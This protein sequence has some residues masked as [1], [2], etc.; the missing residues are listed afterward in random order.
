MFVRVFFASCAFACCV[1]CITQ[2][3]LVC[4]LRTCILFLCASVRLC[5]RLCLV[6]VCLWFVSSC[7]IP[8]FLVTL[9]ELIPVPG[10]CVFEVHIS[11]SVGI[12]C[13]PACLS[14]CNGP[15]VIVAVFSLL[16]YH[17]QL[18]MIS[19]ELSGLTSL[20]LDS[21]DVGDVGVRALSSMTRLEVRLLFA[22]K[23][24]L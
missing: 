15:L 1:A 20:I 6:F 14:V 24:E 2:W 16:V 17:Q 4:F 7:G 22:A 18:Q 21:C 11:V 9:H 13:V 8:L 19:R 3:C 23:R 5:F 12:Y 10:L